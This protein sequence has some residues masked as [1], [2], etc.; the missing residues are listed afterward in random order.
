ME[1]LR[2]FCLLQSSFFTLVEVIAL[3]RFGETDHESF[4]VWSGSK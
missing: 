2:K 1:K 3:R 4:L